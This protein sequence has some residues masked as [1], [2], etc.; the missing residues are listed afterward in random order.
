MPRS[1]RIPKTLYR[2]LQDLDD[3]FYLLEGALTK[4]PAVDDVYLKSLAAELRVLVCHSS[5]TEGLIWR[6]ADELDI[7]DWVNVHLAGNV[8]QGHPLAEGLDFAFVPIFRA[9]QGDPRLTPAYYS[10]KGIVKEC[11]AIFVSRKGYTHEQLIKAV[12]QQMGSAHE[13]DS[14]EEYLVDLSETLILNKAPLVEVLASD[15]DL[16]L[17]V[18]S[19]ILEA[20]T[21]NLGFSRK[22]RPRHI[23]EEPVVSQ[24][25]PPG[26][27]HFETG[28]SELPK[29]GTVMFSMNH[30]HSDW[31]TNSNGYSFGVFKKGVLS[32]SSTKHPDG[33]MELTITG[34]KDRPILTRQ[35]IPASEFPGVTIAITWNEGEVVVYI[36]GQRVDAIRLTTEG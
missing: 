26:E 10:L 8:D 25:P 13:D 34:L 14:V 16:V 17:E 31:I 33:T 20:A 7:Q 24:Q 29:E 2:K 11:Q 23:V 32:I 12:A 3:H 22:H 19:R 15:A 4:L 6:L 18:G 27:K 1:R 28:E 30:P 5:G 9:G 21:Q 35:G 36:N